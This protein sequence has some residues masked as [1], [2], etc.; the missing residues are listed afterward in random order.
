MKLRKRTSSRL[1]H[2]LILQRE[3]RT[4][5]DIGGYN[6]TWTNVAD[7]WAEIIPMSGSEKLLGGQIQAQLT[8]KIHLRYRDGVDASMRLVF[9]NRAFNIRYIT[10]VSENNEL[11]EILAEEGVAN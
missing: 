2:K 6:K 3:V 8:H 10:N 4:P 11:L 7:I 1:R 5:D 9:E